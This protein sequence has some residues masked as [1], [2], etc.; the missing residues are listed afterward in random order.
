M[1]RLDDIEPAIT[2]FTPRRDPQ[3]RQRRRSAVTLLLRERPR[4]GVN[5]LMIQRA[6]RVGDPWSGHMAFPGG[7][8]DADDR[9]SFAAAA[10][11]CREEVGFDVEHSAHYLGR[12]SDLETH[13]RSGT[14]SMLVTPFLFALPDDPLL[15]PNHEVAEI[16]WVPLSFLADLGNR[17]RMRLQRDV[18]ELDLPCYWYRGKQIWGL[19]LGM[20]DELLGLISVG[21]PEPVRPDPESGIP[22]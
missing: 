16:V 14:S 21:H 18:G 20:L 15:A 6:E 5:V 3:R 11:E 8:M 19:S 9:H 7:R 10:R 17:R 12:L 22:R 2:A 13:L 1:Y 4:T